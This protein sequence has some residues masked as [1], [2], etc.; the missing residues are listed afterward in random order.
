MT[1]FGS[2]DLRVT[3][4]SL[5]GRFRRDPLLWVA[6][7]VA[8]A[9]WPVWGALS[10]LPDTHAEDGILTVRIVA[11]E[12]VAFD[13]N[14]VAVTF[15][16]ADGGPLPR[17]YAGSHVDLLLPSGRIRQ[18]SL[19]GDP[20]D[21]SIYRIAVRRIPDGGGG[22]VEVHDELEIG[23]ALS[24]RGPRNA[25]PLVLPGVA[26]GTDPAAKHLRFVAGGIGIT[27]I[28][29]MLSHAE[30]LGYDWSMIYT[31]RSRES[32]PFL[33][34]LER[35]GDKITVRTDDEH[36]LPDADDLVG[37]LDGE[38]PIALYCCGPV[39]MIDLL[40]AHLDGRRDLE[41]HYERFSPPPV[42]GGS[43][44]TVN[45][46]RSGTSTTVAAEESLLAALRRVHPGVPYSCQQGFCGT[47]RL[48]VVD[49]EPEHRDTLLSDDERTDGSILTCVSRC[50]G[51]HLTLD[52]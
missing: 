26:D 39:P 42:V 8:K 43:E 29:P 6:T 33:H 31:G 28:L 2:P 44:F 11:R 14:V 18:Y 48:R 1:T 47:C 17:W 34:E 32:I 22:S 41:L 52:L 51:T 25:F 5:R 35:Y 38:R 21:Q 10:R 12:R 23:D 9:W 30:R 49:G 27:P 45:L 15:A 50:A 19:C 13:E 7:G 46:A 4:P 37:R 20:A 36:G 16:S 3:P 24:I 40:R